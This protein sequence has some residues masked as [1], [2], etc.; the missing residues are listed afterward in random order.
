MTIGPGWAVE[1]P[2]ASRRCFQQLH[3]LKIRLE[4]YAGRELSTLS[5][6]MTS[7]FEVAIEEGSTM[8]RIG[9]AIFG[10]RY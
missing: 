1:D 7:D 8:V 9:T 10:P 3:D 6:G 2:E 4:Q 5:M